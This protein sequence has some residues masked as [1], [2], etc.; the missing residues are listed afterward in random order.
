MAPP[1]HTDQV[2]SLVRPE[3]LL[4]AREGL[5]YNYY[6]PNSLPADLQATTENAVKE[7]VAKQVENGIRPITS[8]EFERTIFYGGFFEMLD[9]MTVAEKLPMPSAFRTHLPTVNALMAMGATHNSAV[10]ASAKIEWVRSAYL[11]GWEMLVKAL[12]EGVS[13]AECKISIPSPTWVHMQVKPGTAWTEASPYRSDREYFSD[14]AAAFRAELRALYDAG[15]RS[16]QIDDPNL[17]YFVVDSF[18]E[19][20][21]E[22]G[23]DP[24][25]LL[26]LYIWAC[27]ECLRDLPEDLH[28]SIHICRGNFSEGRNIVQSGSYEGIARQ[29]FSGLNFETFCLEFD[30]ERSGSFEPL[31]FLPVGKRVALGLVSTKTSQLED[32]AALER[33][34]YEAAE[35]VATGQGRPV[36][37]VV[38]DSLAISPQ[39]GF[40]SYSVGKGK[41][42][43]EDI[44][45]AKL[46]LV[47][48]VAQK[49]WSPETRVL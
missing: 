36:D 45:W 49:V 18:R 5:K 40:A 9:G 37:D 7:V 20:C 44:Q 41:G 15:L 39:C 32:G 26:D 35:V 38:R 34:V 27:N 25:E 46:A 42:M 21:R 31:R 24:D 16:V 29:V 23:V 30:D 4:A 2:G 28:T 12:P 11:H 14:L 8:G 1:F 6:Q 19:G 33:R 10:V 3:S 22:D 13:P 48:D 47:R 43:T 17:I